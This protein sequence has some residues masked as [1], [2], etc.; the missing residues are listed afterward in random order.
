[1]DVNRRAMNDDPPADEAQRNVWLHYLLDLE[2]SPALPPSHRLLLGILRQA[3]VD[4][5]GDDPVHQ[6]S[7]ALYFASSPLYRETLQAF[8]LPEDALP[9]GVDLTAFRRKEKMDPQ[10][11]PDSLQLEMLVRELTGNQLK[12]VLTMGLMELPVVTRKIS[13]RCDLTRSTVLIAMNH[14]ESQ[15]LVVRHEFDGRPAW[16]FPAAVGKIINEVWRPK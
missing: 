6:F 11:E 14:L 13:L 3:V 4:Y 16:S 9:L 12:I 5:F 2:I 15:G 1:M 8:N 7:A 10:D